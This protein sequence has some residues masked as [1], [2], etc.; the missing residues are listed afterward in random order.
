MRICD[1]P[2]TKMGG[3]IESPDGSAFYTFARVIDRG[4]TT[5]IAVYHTTDG[6]EFVTDIATTTSELVDKVQRRHP[7]WTFHL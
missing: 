4:L 1:L 2:R 3:S 7:A 5:Y 6:F